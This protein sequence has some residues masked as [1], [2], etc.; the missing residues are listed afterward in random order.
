MGGI[1]ILRVSDLGSSVNTAHF[2]L[3]EASQ[4]I[5]GLDLNKVSEI[6]HTNSKTLIYLFRNGTLN[7]KQIVN[8]ESRSFLTP[9]C[10]LRLQSGVKPIL[11]TSFLAG[12]IILNMI[13]KDLN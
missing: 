12:S 9:R 2:V 11:N 5:I 10:F 8:N 7:A 4:W 13:W 6:V 3:S 1:D